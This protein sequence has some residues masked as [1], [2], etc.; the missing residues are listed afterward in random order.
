MVTHLCMVGE[1]ESM[2]M[3]ALPHRCPEAVEGILAAG[4][5]AGL[6]CGAHRLQSLV[7][8][9][10]SSQSSRRGSINGRGKEICQ[11]WWE[12]ECNITQVSGT[13]FSQFIEVVY[14]PLLVL[15]MYFISIT[16]LFLQFF[17]VTTSSRHKSLM[18]SVNISTSTLEFL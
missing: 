11:V 16:L 10:A 6:H 2:T 7:E 8:K 15:C 13:G 12:Q 4:W 5:E 14:I 3:Y 9:T 18:S 1:A 17:C